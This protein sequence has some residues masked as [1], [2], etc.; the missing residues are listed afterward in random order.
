MI[1]AGV[2]L[3][4][5]KDGYKAGREVARGAQETMTA[6]PKI[7]ILVVDS[8]ARKPH[9]YSNVL[10][11]VRE[12][13]GPGIDIIGSTV[14]GILVEDRIALRSVGLMLLGGDINIEN[15]FN[16]PHSRINYK[17][18]AK[19]I[20]KKNKKLEPNDD[21][22]MLLFQDGIKLPQEVLDKQKSLNSR[23][24][25]IFT[26]II[27][28]FFMKQIDQLKEKGMG[29]PSVQ[30]FLEEL[31]D[32][33]WSNQVIGNIASNLRNYDSIQFYNDQIGD[34][35]IVGATIA[36]MGSDKFGFGFAAGAEP[37]GK[38]CTIDKNIGS[39]LLKI[40]GESAIEGLCEAA[41]I[42]KKALREL[43][44]S[45]YL[46]YHTIIGTTEEHNGETIP[47]LTATITDPELENL[48]NT[49]FPFEKVPDEVDIFQSNMEILH[50]TA[51][52]AVKESLKNISDPQFLLGFDCAI[53]FFAYGDN[54]PRIIKTIDDAIGKDIP[55]MIVGS[56]GEIFGNKDIDYYFNNMTFVT[57]AGGK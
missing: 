24:V 19:K 51:E 15:T 26:G 42:K 35:N 6:N 46:N 57:L 37:T 20:Y 32:L 53:R 44:G 48:I 5:E 56:G 40:N 8:L 1:D 25:S 52:K 33:S 12:E 18:I 16:Y 4:T 45:D 14:N 41:D 31:Y 29:M 22:F 34:D 9:N 10:K 17:E 21:R 43:K 11:G 13:L 28:R 47:H 54:F 30:E 7:G 38:S 55:R 36:P 39:F 50:R 23:F 3:S 49:G 2:E 27:K